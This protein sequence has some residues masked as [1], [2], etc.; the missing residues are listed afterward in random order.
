MEH[1]T[2]LRNLTELQE[3]VLKL[4]RA[5]HN[6]QSIA[7]ILNRAQST[8]SGVF[9]LLEQKGYNVHRYYV[10]KKSIPDYKK[11]LDN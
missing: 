3:A 2:T 9:V 4:N 8:I 5:G 10:M 7:K 1:D 6:Q 11:Y